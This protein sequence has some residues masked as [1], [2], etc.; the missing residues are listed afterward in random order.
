MK[1][2]LELDD[3]SRAIVSTIAYFDIFDY[4]LTL[5]EIYKWLYQKESIIADISGALASGKLDEVIENKNGFYFL[6]GRQDIIATRLSR[7]VIAEG[8]FEIALRAA[9]WLRYLPFIRLVAVCNN[10]GYNNSE[11]RS[12]IDFFIVTYRGRIW[13]VRLLVTALL[14]LLGLRHHGRKIT[15]RICLSFYIASDQLNLIDV[16]LKPTDIYLTY[17]LATLAPIYDPKNIYPNFFRANLWVKTYLPN[18]Y[19][20]YLTAQRIVKDN[21]W[22]KFSKSFDELVFS[23]LI[24]DWLEKLSR[25]IQIKKIRKYLGDL[26]EKPN[27]QVVLSSS[28]LKFHK[29]DRRGYFCQ[30][31]QKN[32]NNIMR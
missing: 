1:G 8:K 12:D 5:V 25:L 24:G 28:M 30:L 9:R 6:K 7:Y 19:P 31:W 22:A 26:A 4:P 18:F 15:N 2:R 11:A 21:F 17:W 16:A 3:L 23:G 27:F 10:L 13:W 32:L 14:T 29:T 20:T